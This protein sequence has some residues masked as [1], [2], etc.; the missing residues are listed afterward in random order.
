LFSRGDRDNDTLDGGTGNDLL[1]GSYDADSLL[2]GEGNDTL[3]GDD[4]RDTLEGGAGNDT[5]IGGD[6][7]DTFVFGPNS[8]QDRVDGGLGRDHLVFEQKLSN[9]STIQETGITTIAL[10]DGSQVQATDVEI[11]RFAGGDF[12]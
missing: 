9:I 1:S 10:E 11:V 2:G 5:L 3:S 7:G 6:G 8:G 12:I 4:G